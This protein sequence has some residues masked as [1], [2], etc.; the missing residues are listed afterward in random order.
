MGENLLEEIYKIENKF[1]SQS[2]AAL[3]INI[4]DLD[5]PNFNVD[6]FIVL[7]FSLRD[8]DKFDRALDVPK[9]QKSVDYFLQI[10]KQTCEE[11]VDSIDKNL[12]KYIEISSQFEKMK[13]KLQKTSQKFDTFNNTIVQYTEKTK[14]NK[15]KIDNTLSSYRNLQNMESIHSSVKY[16]LSILKDCHETIVNLDNASKRKFYL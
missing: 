15:E 7:N 14:A 3:G 11:I 5:S 8:K 16:F 6:K 12:E 4:E 9:V 13:E 1:F 2:H 10:Q